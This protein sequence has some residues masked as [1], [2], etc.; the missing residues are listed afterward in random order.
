[1]DVKDV[2]DF[3]INND[4][5]TETAYWK[6]ILKMSNMSPKMAGTVECRYECGIGG[7]I[8]GKNIVIILVEDLITTCFNHLP[9]YHFSF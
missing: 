5:F 3:V 9:S 4:L 8:S 6:T 2:D 7:S 1:M